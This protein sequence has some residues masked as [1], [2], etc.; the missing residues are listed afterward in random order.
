MCLEKF[1]SWIHFFFVKQFAHCLWNLLNFF[2]TIES[3]L[4]FSDLKI[5]TSSS[6]YKIFL[7]HEYFYIKVGRDPWCYHLACFLYYSNH[8]CGPFDYVTWES[9]FL[10]SKIN[11]I[12]LTFVLTGVVWGFYI[13]SKKGIGKINTPLCFY[14]IDASRSHC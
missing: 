2:L 10:N 1:K 13:A 5:H 4:L 3:W 8:L 14:S 9:D 12:K 7:K 6:T 11:S